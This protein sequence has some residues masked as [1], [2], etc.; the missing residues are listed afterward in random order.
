MQDIGPS[1][2]FCPGDRPERFS[3][4]TAVADTAVLDL[5]DGV[6]STA[7]DGARDNVCSFLKER[8]LKT[9]VVRINHPKTQRGRD[10]ASSVLAAGCDLLL[11]PKTETVAEVDAVVSS[12]KG[13]GPRLIV[14]VE[15]ARGLLALG[16]ILAHPSVAAVAWGP[17]DLGADLGARTIRGADG[18][19]LSPFSQA[20]NVILFHAAAAQVI[21][22]DT[23]TTELSND[24]AM[25][26][27][28]AEN[29]AQLG[30]AGKFAIHPSQIE[31]IRRAFA[32][33]QAE[34]DRAR[35]LISA[36]EGRGAMSFEGDMID[37]PMV[38]R[39]RRIVEAFRRYVNAGDA[40]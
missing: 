6:A 16:E 27:R 34:V 26:V 28:D 10:D 19:Y 13:V 37:E 33:S 5:E 29:A 15:T 3:K 11:L 21:A 23:V 39:A 18:A 4:A 22:L 36:A 30:F 40:R 20:R 35:R 32:P 38:R 9:V 8:G 24:A 12:A 2:L 14:T 7:K 17:Y 1:L 31:T 25:L